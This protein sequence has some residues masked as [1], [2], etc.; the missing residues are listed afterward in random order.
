MSRQPF[1]PREL[2]RDEEDLRPLVRALAAH[3]NE[4]VTPRRGLIDEIVTRLEREPPANPINGFMWAV[5]DGSI[6]GAGQ[7]LLGCWR[8]A[9][10]GVMVSRVLRLQAAVL[11]LAVAL[12]GAASVSAA[13]VGANVLLQAITAPDAPAVECPDQPGE[14]EP[15]VDEPEASPSVE[16]SDAETD[17]PGNYQ[18]GQQGPSETDASC[19]DSEGQEGEQG[20]TGTNEGG[21][22][23]EGPSGND[24]ASSPDADQGAA[25]DGSDEAGPSSSADD[26]ASGDGSSGDGSSGDGANP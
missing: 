23:N 20:P 24:G 13:A 2:G 11:L 17:N 3:A 25:S 22:G 26:G 7:A 19:P 8:L 16:P 10:G 1:D 4:V 18:S 15:G 12:G 21:S 14:G 9:V 6:R 5:Q